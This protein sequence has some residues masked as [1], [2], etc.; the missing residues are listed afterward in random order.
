VTATGPE[1]PA[2]VSR[3][4]ARLVARL[5]PSLDVHAVQTLRTWGRLLDVHLSAREARDLLREAAP[6]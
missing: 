2:V 1:A 6:R 4:L 3:V 5:E